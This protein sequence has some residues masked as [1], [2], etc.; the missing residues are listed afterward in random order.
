MI[1]PNDDNIETPAIKVPGDQ[2]TKIKK[3]AVDNPII[4]SF[5]KTNIKP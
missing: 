3:A 2:R 4:P 5:E 1:Y